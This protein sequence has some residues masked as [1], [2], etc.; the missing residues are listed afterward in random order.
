[1]AG[2]EATASAPSPE[3]WPFRNQLILTLAA[4]W[5]LL[6]GFDK[7]LIGTVKTDGDR[8]VDGRPEFLA[9]I[10]AVIRL[11]EGGLVVEAPAIA[12][13]SPALVQASGIP[14]SV[15][16]WTHSC[17]VASFACGSCPG[18][19]KRASVLRSIGRLE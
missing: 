4:G 17:N 11:Q 7:L 8:H 13:S 5:A 19:T 15:L 12:L 9:L 18:C 1:M 6:K 2:G 16:A 10:S 14:D 3:W